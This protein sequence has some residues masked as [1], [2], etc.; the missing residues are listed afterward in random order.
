MLCFRA[1]ISDRSFA[2][3]ERTATRMNAATNCEVRTWWTRYL[4]N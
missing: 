3:L 2:V 4:S 1:E